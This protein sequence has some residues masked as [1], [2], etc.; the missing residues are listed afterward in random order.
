MQIILILR[1]SNV[2]VANNTTVGLAPVYI[3]NLTNNTAYISNCSFVNNTGS[4]Y[5]V[6]F[7]GKMNI[8]NCIFDNYTQN[9]ISFLYVTGTDYPMQVSNNLINN[10]PNS[11][12]VNPSL[13]INFNDYNFTANPSFAGTDWTNPLSYR[14]NYNSPCIDAGTPD[15]TGLFLPFFDLYGNPRIYNDIVDIGCNEWNG[16]ANQDDIVTH[17][18]S[19]VSIYPNPFRDITCISYSLAKET[20][21]S[22]EVYNI[23]GQRVITLEH[24][25]HA[26]GDYKLTWNGIDDQGKAVSSGMYIL[27]LKA[28]DDVVTKKFMVQ[29]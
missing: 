10:Y 21:V 23:K 16:T 14:L 27:R 22:L 13:Q 2:L 9:E 5:A 26:R 15:T 4:T 25:I 18:S 17:S 1:M 20:N 7:N 24:G 29:K 12:Y 8:S 11:I 19:L 3:D 28:R 6:K